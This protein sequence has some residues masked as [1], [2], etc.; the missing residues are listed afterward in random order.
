MQ[1]LATGGY[2]CTD[3]H[4]GD[5]MVLT[6]EFIRLKGVTTRE[7]NLMLQKYLKQGGNS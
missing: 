7:G 6:T 4:I 3:L 5:T 2:E 1:V